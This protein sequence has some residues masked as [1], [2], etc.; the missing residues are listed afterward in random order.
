MEDKSTVN[1]TPQTP[2]EASP[3]PIVEPALEPK[4]SRFLTKKWLFLGVILLV[5]IFI[6]VI[7]NFY[8]A[9]FGKKNVATNNIAKTT[10]TL[11]PKQEI[12]L[13]LLTN[14]TASE[15]ATWKTY[16][17][18][19]ANISLKL[20]PDWIE[21]PQPIAPGWTENSHIFSSSTNNTDSKSKYQEFIIEPYKSNNLNFADIVK[22]NNQNNPRYPVKQ[23]III[24]GIECIYQTSNALTQ[25]TLET[26]EQSMFTECAAND[27]DYSIYFTNYNMQTDDILFKKILSTLKFTSQSSQASNSAT[28]TPTCIP[29]PA[30]LD[31]TPRCMIAIT[32]NMCPPTV[33]PTR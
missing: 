7:S 27:E 12:N 5:L 24:D 21:K 8:L 2:V 10:P 16:N 4:K 15:A 32:S 6:G 11:L 28:P 20:P 18:S 31:A 3:K 9:S 33:T 14:L 26:K 25:V 19:D 13:V 23:K 17:L 1:N 30:C 29:R 22:T